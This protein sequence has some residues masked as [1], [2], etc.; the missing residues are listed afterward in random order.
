VINLWG[1]DKNFDIYLQRI[2][3]SFEQKVLIMRTGRPGNIVVFGFNKAPINLS[4]ASLQQRAKELEVQH[5]IE[6]TDFVDKLSNDNQVYQKR[7]LL[8]GDA[9]N[10]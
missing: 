5:E 6:F 3:Q 8:R 2:E 9:S 10:N 4:I 1:S 7:L